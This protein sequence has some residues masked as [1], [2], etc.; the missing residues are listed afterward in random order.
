[1]IE[2]KSIK[3]MNLQPVYNAILAIKAKEGSYQQATDGLPK[4]QS[5][6]AV[7]ND[8]GNY[9]PKAFLNQWFSKLNPKNFGPLPASMPPMVNES[10][11]D[12]F[13]KANPADVVASDILAK[14]AQVSASTF[15]NLLKKNGVELVLNPVLTKEATG[16]SSLPQMVREGDN[17]KPGNINFKS[18]KFL[19][20]S[21]GINGE[22]AG[23]FSRF[24]TV[25][26]TEGLGNL[27]DLYY[28]S[29]EALASAVP[30]FEG[31]K[32]YAD[33]PT[34]IQE[35]MQPERS[36]RDVLG[37]FENVHLE[38]NS[39]GQAMLVGDVVIPMD[40]PF[41]WA[42]SLMAHS[43]DYAKKYPDKDFVG[44]SINASG[45]AEM[46]EIDKVI[47]IAPMNAKLKIQKAKE[48][49]KQT[50]KLVSNIA[51]AVSCD[52]VTEAGAGGKILE[53]LE[54]DLKMKKE[55]KKETKKE[56]I[57]EKKE[58]MPMTKDEQEIAPSSDKA[59]GVDPQHDDAAQDAELI[60]Q[61]IAKYMG[62]DEMASEEE[63]GIVK[64]CYEACMEMGMG[65]SEAAETAVKQ[66]K[67]AKHMVAKKMKQE[68]ESVKVDAEDGV[69][70]GSPTE[71]EAQESM[72]PMDPKAAGHKESAIALTA[73][74]AK[75]EAQVSAYKV[76]EHLEKVLEAS[77]LPRSATKHF[78]TLV[79]SA[80]STQEI[81]QSFKI[82]EAGFKGSSTV[83]AKSD[84]FENMIVQPE[85]TVQAK[86]SKGLALDGVFRK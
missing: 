64:E 48:E 47:E 83:G 71:M 63:C 8:T 15:L 40:D 6:E 77:K 84:L 80:K 4:K 62:A 11:E 13:I 85:K 54:G 56:A 14:N 73:K 59:M 52:L 20:K 21:S 26:L 65:E 31:K 23:S 27:R 69:V 17:K 39:D 78:R 7:V 46:M 41:M 33:H 70:A 5:T 53:L 16:S 12:V 45:D 61:M 55:A 36:V 72:P 35:Q 25:L 30:V 18:G 75:L 38:E 29:K 86:A 58:T 66:L 2:N 3:Q 24:K 44:L 34:A 42:R 67:L 74:L 68:A 37:H 19:E 10:N 28:Y 50:V 22:P 43:V 9:G 49:G 60:K 1:M 32:I 81:D 76:K 57:M 51:E 79:E 82:F